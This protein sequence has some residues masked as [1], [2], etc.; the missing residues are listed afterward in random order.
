MRSQESLKVVPEG[1]PVRH[2][3]LKN[4]TRRIPRCCQ[5]FVHRLYNLVHPKCDQNT[6]G[7]DADDSGDCRMAVKGKEC[8]FFL[9][10]CIF[11]HKFFSRH[12]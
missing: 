10:F 9:G 5:I 8:N 4:L 2:L 3:T 12:N 7:S 1:T 6:L 11:S